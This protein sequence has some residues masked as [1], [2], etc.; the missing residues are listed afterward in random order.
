MLTSE[1]IKYF[2]ENKGEITPE[3]LDALREQGNEGKNQAIEILD[4]PK[5]AEMYYLDSSGHPISYNSMKTL[6]KPD[7]LLELHPIHLSEI[8]RCAKDFLYFRNNYIK[9]KTKSGISFPDFRP[10]QERF[11]EKILDDN[12]EQVI[13]LMGRQCIDGNT[14]LRTNRGVMTIEELWESVV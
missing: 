5:N 9:I 6:K 14:L 13:G 10:Y 3:L 12:N 4:L 8:E 11:I 1:E 2:F 7:V